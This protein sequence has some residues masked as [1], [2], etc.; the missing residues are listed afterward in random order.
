MAMT[1][2]ATAVQ[3]IL[4]TYFKSPAIQ[5]TI[6][7][8]QSAVWRDTKRDVTDG[9][10]DYCKFTQYLDEPFTISADDT[11][12]LAMAAEESATIGLKFQMPWQELCGPIRIS[13]KAAALAK[14]DRVAWFQLTALMQAAV[15]RQQHH[16]LSILVLGFGW[17][18]LAATG[19]TYGGSGASFTVSNGAIN[20]FVKG[21]KIVGADSLHADALRSGTAIKVSAVN[22]GT[23]TVTCATALTTPGILT[24]DFVF[25]AGMRQNSASPS[26]VVGVGLR[27][28]FP[29]VRPVVDAT[30]ST[31][32]GTDRSTNDRAYGQYV[33]GS[34]LDDLNAL[35]K[36]AQRC[37]ILGNATKLKCYVSHARYT[38]MADTLNGDRR[39]TAND[40][41]TSGFL[42]LSVLA[43][44]IRV[45]CEIDR[46]LE[47]DVGYMLESGSVECIG[48]GGAVPHVDENTW[49]RVADGFGK[50]LRTYALYAFIVNDPAPCGVVSFAALA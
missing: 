7:K 22:Y 23:D 47:D 44:E 12:A 41:G 5:N 10:G 37:V 36:L 35:E 6:N 27:T 4:K 16:V 2:G 30:I 42:K 28:W 45:A 21:M 13:D 46:N 24:G 38:A 9:G 39:F 34:A 25:M 3:G 43:S 48:A 11:T 8:K 18:E 31:V 14:T 33:D 26:R 17:G 15:L 19:I 20:H 1:V 29:S 49:E 50:E 32:E 40:D